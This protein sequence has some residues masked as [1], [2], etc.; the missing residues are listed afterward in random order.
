MLCGTGGKTDAFPCDLAVPSPALSL[1]S[2]CARPR[3]Y[4]RGFLA[5]ACGPGRRRIAGSTTGPVPGKTRLRGEAALGWATG[6]AFGRWALRSARLADCHSTPPS[7][8]KRTGAGVA[9]D[10]LWISYRAAPGTP[11]PPGHRLLGGLSFVLAILR[12]AF[13]RRQVCWATRQDAPGATI[14][15]PAAL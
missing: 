4:L 13:A 12:C 2:G 11:S 8:D 7:L 14:Y 1:P 6:G 3:P 15:S 5:V 10:C 9:L